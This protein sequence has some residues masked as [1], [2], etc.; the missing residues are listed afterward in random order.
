LQQKR[1]HVTARPTVGLRQSQISERAELYFEYVG[2]SA[3][4]GALS[5]L[6]LHL[7]S[8]DLPGST[9]YLL[10]VQKV[11]DSEGVRTVLFNRTRAQGCAFTVPSVGTYE[12][13]FD[14]VPPGS[15]GRLVLADESQLWPTNAQGERA[16]SDVRAVY[17]STRT[18]SPS[19]SHTPPPDPTIACT[20]SMTD[21]FTDG[22]CRL[23]R[24]NYAILATCLFTFTL[25]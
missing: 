21:V 3:S 12:L 16:A 6:L 25:W 11:S 4:E 1:C 17:F 22:I 5:P 2:N 7:I 15:R 10:T 14:S 8:T 19:V 23:S 9:P 20:P 18:P 13:F 24:M